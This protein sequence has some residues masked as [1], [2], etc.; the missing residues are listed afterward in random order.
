M[1]IAILIPGIAVILFV[2]IAGCTTNTGGQ[3]VPITP[4]AVSTP[5]TIA[6]PSSTVTEAPV[7]TVTTTAQPTI[8]VPDPFGEN[9]NVKTIA[10]IT[11]GSGHQLVNVTIPY[12]Y[13]EMWYTADP[14]STGGQ[15]SHAATGSQSA[16]FPSLSIVVRDPATGQE[17]GTVEPPGGL[18][19]TLWQ[20]SGDPRPWSKKFY[21]GD[22]E[23]AFDITA[24]HIISYTIGVRIPKS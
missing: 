8:Q 12:G 11:G 4:T 16:V 14:I 1:R 24:R 18:D 5:V 22:K 20:R 15:E 9:P 19:T 7:V 6:T 10:S 13:W 17:I 2:L 23:L 3:N 21:V